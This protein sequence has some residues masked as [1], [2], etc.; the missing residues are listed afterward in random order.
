MINIL[1]YGL[2][3]TLLFTNL[4]HAAPVD[5]I[6]LGIILGGNYAPKVDLEF[7]SLVNHPTF[8]SVGTL[9]YDFGGNMG[10]GIGYKINNFRVEGEFNYAYLGFNKLQLG[11]IVITKKRSLT[12]PKL[13]GNT[14]IMSF[15][16]NGFYDLFNPDPETNFIP[17]VG[18]G[19]G[20]AQF[21]N[22]TD[23][24]FQNRI[25]VKTIESVSGG[26]V[27]GILGFRYY[28]DD[29]TSFSLDYR[30]FT[31]NKIKEDSGL[32]TQRFTMSSIN[33]N[34]NFALAS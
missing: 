16:V 17:Y 6:Y 22:T 21:R 1:K 3:T 29:Y 18:L 25:L 31:T 19:I 13:G 2:A 20:M 4:S 34:F 32:F 5:G 30:Y 26:A 23:L 10:G 7:P 9:T 24:T 14:R 8:Y 11:D 28:L 12:T 33:L 15:F 27:Q